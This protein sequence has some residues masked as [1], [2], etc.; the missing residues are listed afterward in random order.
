MKFMKNFLLLGVV[1]TLADLLTYSALL[2]LNI[3]YILAITV[4][5]FVGFIVNFYGGRKFVF[6]KGSKFGSVT[7]E[8]LMVKLI[9]VAGLLFNLAIVYMLFEVLHILDAFWARIIAIGTVF[10]WNFVARKLWVYN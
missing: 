3:H 4:G 6:T 2:A 1:S 10:V 7:K 9:V 8:Y 5:Y